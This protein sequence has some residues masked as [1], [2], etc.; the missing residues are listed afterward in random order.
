MLFL[1]VLILA[2]EGLCTIPPQDIPPFYFCVVKLLWDSLDQFILF[3]EVNILGNAIL[4]ALMSHFRQI[5]PG[6]EVYPRFFLNSFYY[7]FLLPVLTLPKIQYFRGQKNYSQPFTKSQM[8][9]F[10]F[11]IIIIV[12]TTVIIYIWSPSTRD[13]LIDSS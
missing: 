3:V 9:F 13:L 2:L 11:S 8:K 7:Y 5:V 12:T 10:Y 4:L 1:R 6:L